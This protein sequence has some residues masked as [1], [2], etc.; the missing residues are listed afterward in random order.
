MWLLSFCCSSSRHWNSGNFIW[1]V[2][3][4]ELFSLPSMHMLIRTCWHLSLSFVL[5]VIIN[6][7]LNYDVWC[8]KGTYSTISCEMHVL[9][10]CSYKQSVKL[11]SLWPQYGREKET[12]FNCLCMH[13]L[14]FKFL[15][16]PRQL[17]NYRN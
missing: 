4:S 14:N 5:Q 6:D 16:F 11:D 12:G 9:Y 7:L 15:R 17:W 13:Y 10:L 2:S 3:Q 8:I 1:L